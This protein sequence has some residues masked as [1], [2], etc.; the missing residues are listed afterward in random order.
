[1]E[2]L[3]NI[4]QN[5]WCKATFVYTERDMIVD[6]QGNKI[7]PRVCH[8]CKSFDNE[9]SGGVSWEDREYEGERIDDKPHQ[10][11]YKVTNFKI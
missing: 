6:K 10:I 9:L 7:R 11:R 5:P 2:E 3:T 8:K 4:C 1:M